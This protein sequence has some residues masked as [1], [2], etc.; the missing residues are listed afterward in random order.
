MNLC[1][2]LKQVPVSG[3]EVMGED[4]VLRRERGE[5]RMNPHDG[6]ALEAALRLRDAA[7]G[8]VTVLSMGPPAARVMLS[9][10][11][12]IG[13]DEAVLITDPC[14]TGADVL[15]TAYALAC[16]IRRIG[17]FDY[18]LCGDFTTDGGTGHTAGE[19]AA[20]LELPYLGA[21]TR[22]S[23]MTATLRMERF[24]EDIRLD[25][26]AVLSVLPDAYTLRLPGL[27]SR[28]LATEKPLRRLDVL[29]IGADPLRCGIAGSATRV[30]KIVPAA[31]RFCEKAESMPSEEAAKRIW[32]AFA[33]GGG[34][35]I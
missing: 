29:A 15:A 6:A 3:A 21:V 8:R 7:G 2:C 12:T 24:E 32:T 35:A 23:E 5:R 17:P 14:F 4:G 30:E 1:V 28:L 18:I 34:E 9:E 11:L 20:R 33:R 19:L 22:L 10:A 25:T 31:V 16:A 27:S 26:A 13:A